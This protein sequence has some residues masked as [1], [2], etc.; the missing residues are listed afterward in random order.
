MLLSV[1]RKTL[2]PQTR[3]TIFFAL[4]DLPSSFDKDEKHRSR[5][6]LEFEDTSA[7][8]QLVAAGV[9][10]D[11]LAKKSLLHFLADDGSGKQQLLKLPLN[12]ALPRVDEQE[13]LQ[14]RK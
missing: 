12:R 7:P 5:D 4:N 9:E 2:F 6:P 1:S 13:R 14:I 3:S 11:S 8:A 10:L